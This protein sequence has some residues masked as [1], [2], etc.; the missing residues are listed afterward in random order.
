MFWI[1]V[2]FQVCAVH[3][4]ALLFSDNDA[5]HGAEERNP[6]YALCYTLASAQRTAKIDAV[7]N[8]SHRYLRLFGIDQGKE[9]SVSERNAN[10]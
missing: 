3:I 5:D 4:F 9:D 7:H 10:E 8:F 6:R 2:S 1:C